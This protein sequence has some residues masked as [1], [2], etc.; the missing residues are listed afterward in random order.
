MKQ[1]QYIALFSILFFSC[2][3]DENIDIPEEN[4]DIPT[5]KTEATYDV[6]ITK[7]IVYA[8]GL[9]HESINSTNATVKQLKLDAY[10]PN[11]SVINRPAI[12]LIHG[13]GFISG[14]KDVASM[15]YLANYFASRGWVAFS[16]NYRLQGDLGT[17]PSAWVPFAQNNLDP[18][19]VDQFFALYPASRDAK[20]ALRWLYA[21]ANNYNIN[22][23]YITVGGGSAGAVTATML[24]VS[25]PED[26]TEEISMTVDPTLATTNLDQ[27]TKVHTVLDFWGSGITV[28]ILNDLYSKQRFD[29]SDAPIIIM[30]GTEDPTVLFSEAEKLRDNY[31]STGVNYEF[32]PLEGKGHGPWNATVN[33]KRLEA[34]C[35]DFIVGQQQLKTE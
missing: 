10:V 5:I 17:V 16:I 8:E 24:G 11:N 2:S 14:S 34:L 3:T 6:T 15:T 28:E 9:S 7:D 33:D 18:S 32:Y 29:T 26:Y 21:N 1:L 22:T 35:F 23:D 20:A 4:Q 30:H 19:A 25:S 27:P 12:L 13:G 31:I